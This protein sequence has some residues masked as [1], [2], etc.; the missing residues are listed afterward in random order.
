MYRYHGILGAH[1]DT[2][3]RLLG[4]NTRGASMREAV[5]QE[6]ECV[7]LSM[8]PVPIWDVIL[9]MQQLKRISAH[10]SDLFEKGR[11]QIVIGTAQRDAMRQLHTA[12][13]SKGLRLTLCPDVL[14]EASRE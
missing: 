9:P 13:H 4:K 6:K 10:V 3:T 14:S 2:I 11:R 7:C 12:I 8:P 5:I 1:D